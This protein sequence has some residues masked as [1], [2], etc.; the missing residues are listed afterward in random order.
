MRL[1][2]VYSR[3][4]ETGLSAGMDAL[5]ADVDAEHPGFRSRVYVFGL[6]DYGARG[7]RN[8]LTANAL[9]LRVKEILQL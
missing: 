1:F 6:T 9:K 4:D 2:L 7:W 5:L 3:Q 8:P